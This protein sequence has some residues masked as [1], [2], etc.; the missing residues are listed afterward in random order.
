MSARR[1]VLPALAVWVA[2]SAL[3]GVRL[4]ALPLPLS[5]MV[6]SLRGSECPDPALL[7]ALLML[8]LP[9]VLLGMSVGAGLGLAG[10]VMQGLFR[11]PLVDPGLVGV[12]SGAALAA[13]ALL[14]LGGSAWSAPWTMTLAALVGGLVAAASV[15]R[16]AQ[17]NGRTAVLPL[18]LAGI[19]VNAVAGALIGA[20]SYIANEAQLRN[21]TFFTL[22]SLGS[23]TWT[24]ALWAA[25]L[26]LFCALLLLRLA[27]PLNVLLLGETEANYL[28][29]AVEPLKRR[30]LLLSVLL[31]AAA[32]A[33]C[34]LVGFVGLIV[35]HVARLLLGADHRYVLPGSALLGAGLLL[36]ADVISRVVVA[37]AELPLGIVTAALGGPFFL[38]LLVRE[39]QSW[40]A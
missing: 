15:Q 17:I 33:L 28:G 11:N 19:A 31:V 9:R 5:C 32:V 26:T 6:P 20:L 23:A 25:P 16:L 8:R 14:V 40:G 13:A 1:A 4:G 3:V 21:L 36:W 2:V 38:G 35:P 18:L 27:R 30:A 22:G 24:R 7:S 39:R 29:V 34:G 10:A 12:S 37:P